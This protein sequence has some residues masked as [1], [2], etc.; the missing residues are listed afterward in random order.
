M[1]HLP[2]FHQSHFLFTYI[3]VLCALQMTS[4]LV[5]RQGSLDMFESYI[6]DPI[7]CQT[8]KASRLSCPL[9]TRVLHSHSTDNVTTTL[10]VGDPVSGV[11][12]S[13]PSVNARIIL[14]SSDFDDIFGFAWAFTQNLKGPGWI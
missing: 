1:F 12:L 6:P 8:L 9:S 13:L 2:L 4:C 3:L 7:N 10:P 14:L 5:S 11:F